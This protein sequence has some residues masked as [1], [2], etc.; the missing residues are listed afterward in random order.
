MTCILLNTLIMALKWFP[1][2]ES[3]S[4]PFVLDVCNYCFAGIF[5]MEAALKI[6]ALRSAYFSDGWNVFDFV[7]V[8]STVAGVLMQQVLNIQVGTII[9]GIRLFRIARLFRL[10]RFMSGLNKI[11]T[12]FLRAIPKLFNVAVLLILLLVLFTTM[13][14]RSFTG[15]WN[16]SR[17]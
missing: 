14:V 17:A 13:G 15:P 16:R 12:T 5:V 8:V 9:I 6:Y 1:E 2:P 7:C 11:F 4:L 10:L 3:G